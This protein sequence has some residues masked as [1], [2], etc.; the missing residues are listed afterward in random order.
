MML[1]FIQIHSLILATNAL[2]IE[3]NILDKESLEKKS[4]KIFSM[5]CEYTSIMAS[6]INSDKDIEN[7]KL[8]DLMRITSELVKECNFEIDSLSESIIKKQFEA[9]SLVPSQK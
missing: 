5:M 8:D 2:L 1:M 7:K 6:E 4:K 9:R 3:K